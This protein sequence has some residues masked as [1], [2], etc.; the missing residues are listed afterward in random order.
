M[1]KFKS[2]VGVSMFKLALML[3][4]AVALAPALARGADAVAMDKAVPK[5]LGAPI[6]LQDPITLT[7]A[8]AKKIGE[9]V[10]VEAEVAMVCQKKGCWMT[11]TDGKE[12]MRMTFKDY[13]FFV[14]KDSRGLKVRAQG[15]IEEKTESVASQRH[16]LKDAGAP[17]EQVDAIKSPKVI[18]S[19][20]ASGITLL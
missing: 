15:V 17:K 18:R 13:G 1:H 9:E 7:Q 6:T 14:P 20:V 16:Y 19:F 2:E 11:V 4:L 8:T 5:S 10:L 12:S 3:T